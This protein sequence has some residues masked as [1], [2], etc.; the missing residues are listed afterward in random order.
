MNSSRIKLMS[1]TA[2]AAVAAVLAGPAFAQ[3][4]PSAPAQSEEDQASYQDTIV[5]TGTRFAAPAS[6]LPISITVIGADDIQANPVFAGNIQNGLSQ[7]IPG[8]TL[9]EVGSSDIVVRG[10]GVSYRVNGVELNQ[11]GRASDIAVQDLEPSAFGQIEVVRGTDAAFGFGFNGGS[12]N[13]STRGPSDGAPQFS[14]LI[15]IDFQPTDAGDSLGWRFRQDVSGTSGRLG[16]YLG[17]SGRFTGN[18]FDSDGNVFPDTNSNFRTSSDVFAF[19]G[20]LVFELTEN[21]ELETKQYY[22]TAEN[23]PEFRA[24]GGDFGAGILSSAEPIP[25]D[26][27]DASSD[28]YNYLGTYTYRHKDLFG[29]QLQVTGF[30][31]DGSGT[32]STDRPGRVVGTRDEGNKRFGVQT[33]LETPLTFLD[34]TL[35]DGAAVVYGVDYQDYEYF[36]TQIDGPLGQNG[37]PFPGVSEETLAGHA[38]ARI[39]I[40]DDFILT[41]GFRIERGEYVLEDAPVRIGR[42]PFE[43][44]A[45]DFEVDLFNAA[46]LYN[47]NDNWAT[48]FAFSQSAG[49]LDVGRG[50]RNV[51]RAVDLDPNLDPTNQY[52]VGFRANYDN[53]AITLAAFYSA[54]D[55]GQSFVP[56]EPGTPSTVVP[57]PIEIWGGEFTI[58]ARL[59]DQLEL[60]GTLSFSDGREEP[61]G[62]EVQIGHTQIQPFKITGYLDYSPTDWWRNKLTLTHQIES[63][64]QADRIAEG[65]RGGNPLESLTFVNYFAT[66]DPDFMPGSIDVGVENIFNLEEVDVVA[67]AFAD[68]ANFYQYPGRRVRIEYKIDW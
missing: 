37:V 23:D 16:Y 33:S 1:A 24:V 54:S 19:D 3:E 59:S 8:G 65:L 6:E 63:D 4:A 9:N 30:V 5:V 43:G 68:S 48:Y 38:Q 18:Q 35:F 44:G 14:S 58:D 57:A 28:A 10:R 46:L 62:V 26:A 12:L 64:A 61:T 22:Y 55:L 49:V 50:S 34:G 31:Q 21:Q 52:E 29:S 25:A 13:L 41:G 40:G 39:P 67:Q 45:I 17:A 42:D 60:G 27:F 51:N 2:A 7:L 11:R 32:F 66:F 36:R 20:T 56:A 53:L 47:V 15:G